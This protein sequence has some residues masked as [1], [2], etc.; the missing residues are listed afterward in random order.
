MPVSAVSLKTVSLPEF[1]EPTVMPLVSRTTYEARIDTLLARGAKSGFDAFV[2]YG[3]RE[4]AA[5][6]AYLSGYDPASR[7][8]C[9]SSFLAGSRNFSSAMRVGVMP[10]PATDLM[11]A[12]SIKPSRCRR[13]RET[14][15]RRCPTF[16]P[17]AA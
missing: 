11:S 2:V 14:V 12:S 9:W 8:R 16:L 7:R 15:R 1:G 17:I 13:S 10:R 4:H 5:N 6:V 3:D